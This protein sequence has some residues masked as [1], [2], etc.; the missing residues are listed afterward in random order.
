MRALALTVLVLFAA[1]ACAPRAKGAEQLLDSVRTY[2]EGLRWQRIPVAASRVPADERAEFIAEWDQLGDDL[3]I[4]DYEVITIADGER[5][6]VVEIKYSWYLDSEQ[7]VHDTRVR[8]EW[9]KQGEIWIRVSAHRLRGVEMPGI[10]EPLDAEDDRVSDV[11]L[12]SSGTPGTD[13]NS[14]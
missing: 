12:G 7:V 9:E 10:A 11:S 6:A 1:V 3:R 2:H 14:D 8:E 5:A 13:D 4:T